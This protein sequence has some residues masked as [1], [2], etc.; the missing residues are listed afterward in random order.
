MRGSR[1][2]CSVAAA[3]VVLETAATAV[4]SRAVP[5]ARDPIGIAWLIFVD[6]LHVDFRNTG[7]LRTLLKSIA[8]DLI[9]D[10]DV[11]AVR[12][13]GPSSLAIDLTADKSRFEDVIAT[14]SGSGLKP[15][16]IQATIGM[17]QATAAQGYG[18]VEYRVK[19]A[20]GAASEMIENVPARNRRRA[21]V[22]VSNGYSADVS[23]RLPALTRAARRANVTMFAIDP[24]S[25]PGSPLANERSAATQ[26]SLRA[27]VESTHG[28]A[29]LH[30]NDFAGGMM[31]MRRAILGGRR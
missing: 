12:S 19:L 24:R 5:A 2:W 27:I 23:A 18:E 22:Y 21:M 31:R 6:D 9:R 8:N 4:Q 28:F 25:L 11:F 26:N 7:Y 15:A 14:A 29:L 13:T 1:F 17:G 30:E 3:V 20:L 16:E 10:R